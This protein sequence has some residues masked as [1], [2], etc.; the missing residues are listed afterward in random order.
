MGLTRG[1]MERVGGSVCARRGVQILAIGLIAVGFLGVRVDQAGGQTVP[2]PLIVVDQAGIV[3]DGES[4]P[5]RR[6]RRFLGGRTVYSGSSSLGGQAIGQ[7]LALARAQ[8]AAL[9]VEQAAAVSSGA[10]GLKVSARAA[11]EG[12]L[13]SVGARLTQ[14]DAAWQPVGPASVVT[15]AYGKVSGR[16]TSIAIDPADATGNTVFVGTTGGGVWKSANAAGSASAVRFVPL[17]DTLPVFSASAG[18]S[19]VASLSIGALSIQRGVMLAGTGDANDA[20]DSYYGGGVLRSDDGGSTW[21]L[22]QGSVDGAAGNHSFVGL[23]FAGFAWSS[24]TPDL[25]VA[26]V[27]DAAEGQIVNAVDAAHAFRGLYYSADAGVTWHMAVVTDRSGT[28]QSPAVQIGGGFAATAVVWNPVRRRFYAA[29]RYRGYYESADGVNWTRLAAQ[30]GTGLAVTA[31]LSGFTTCPIFRGALAVEPVT[32]DLFALT[33]DG[34]NSDQGLWQD[35]CA[36]DGTACA[37][38]VSFAKRLGGTAL[39]VGS[40]SAAVWQGDYNLALAAVRSGSDTLVY[41]GTADVYRCSLAAGCALRNT[42][43]ALNGCGAAAKVAP[44]QHA[45]A[46]LAAGGTGGVAPLVFV[47]NDGGL[48]RS[49]DGIDQRSAVCSADDATHFENLNGGLGSLAEVVRFAQDPTDTGTLLAGLGANG[50]A[51][52]GTAATDG[53][54][55]QLSAGEGGGVAIDPANPANWYVSMGAGV[56]VK[57]CSKGPGCSAADFAG[58]PTIG[59]SQVSGDASLIDAAWMLDP[60]VPGELL[61]GT[62][63]VWRGPVAGGGLWSSSNSISA[64]FGATLP[65]C[66]GSSNMVRSLAAGGPGSSAVSAQNAGATMLYAGMAGAVDGGGTLGGHVFATSAGSTASSAT[67]WLDSATSSVT[68]DLANVKRFNPGGLDI[69]ALIVDSHDATGKTVYATVMGF[70]S[71]TLSVPHVYRSA[72]GGRNWLN[73]SGNLPNAPANDVA[74]DP[75]DANTVYVAMDTGVYVTAQV[76]NCAATNCWSVYGTGLPN[77]PA[78]QLAVAAGMSAGAGQTGELRVGTY[79]RGIWQIPLLA[80]SSSAIAGMRLSATSLKFA[81]Q[82]VGTVSA[83]QTVT[84]TNSGNAPLVVSQIVATGDFHTKETCT[85]AAVAVGGTC[86]VQVSFLPSAIGARSGLVTV[87]GNVAGGQ[88]I[89]S[90]SGTGL[91]GA[92]IVLNPVTISFGSTTVGATSATQNVTI[93]NTGT[94]PLGLASV[95][96]SGDFVVVANTCGG[97]LAP[98]VGCTVGVAFKPTASGARSGALTVTD[99]AGVQTT[100]LSGT[101][102]SPATDALTPLSLVFG[103]QEMNTTSAAQQVTLTNAGDVA[104]TLIGAQVTAGDFTVVNACGNSLNAHSSCSMRVAFVPKSIGAGSGVLTVSDQFRSQA[105]AL[106][107][108]GLAPPGVSLSPFST[109]AFGSVGV[110]NSSAIQR[111]TLTN[112][113]G[114]PL[115]VSGVA[116]TGDYV[117]AAGGTC[118]S[119]VAVGS[120]CEIPVS[121]V[122]KA[123]G[124]RNGTLSVTDSAANSPHSLTLT[125]SGVDFTLTAN[126]STSVTVASGKSAVF[127]LLLSSAAGVPGTAVLT[128]SGAP[129]NA[130]CVIS[131]ASVALGGVTTVSV[132][133]STGLTVASMWREAVGWLAC[134]LPLG[135]FVRRRRLLGF[136]LLGLLAGCGSERRIPGGGSTGGGGGV[137]TPGGSYAITVSATSAGLVRTVGLT[138]LVQ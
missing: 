14:L 65:S 74:V 43:N 26:G 33:V 6:A 61:V 92:A 17:T 7:A 132:T 48:W 78:I 58:T 102:V 118:G 60:L 2:S 86:S 109:L 46:V 32:G 54:W 97:S 3:A 19:A 4:T 34:N 81:A 121:F 70:A 111:V 45:I 110:G 64:M 128:C 112:N 89:V 50:T 82:A 57:A 41:V 105:V 69:S 76:T 108:T 55:T 29:L 114:V 10:A 72:D 107:G 126:G 66:G 87:Y 120:A 117:V 35:V 94:T 133:I 127:P 115:N 135:L 38:A 21:T 49:L 131:P 73:I 100:L 103:A 91:P 129:A 18:T 22:V 99:D 98:G 138:L 84:I 125:G 51:A 119:I 39:E 13:P 77:S 68:N 63:R 9:L 59:A 37:S 44:A 42:T 25:V 1:W 12:S 137:A 124:P 71:P 5:A 96:V 8:H 93:S 31:C 67:V 113:G 134:L 52:I 27:S 85:Q 130:A 122:P 88:A 16:V 80:A 24:A 116:L 95:G 56:S 47:G 28:V 23:G 62:C 30:P 106:S 75:N 90:L 123:G 40:G 79:G 136:V 101:G 104:L 11:A 36:G 20:T 15:A 53:G 83:G